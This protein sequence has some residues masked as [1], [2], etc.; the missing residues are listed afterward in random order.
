MLEVGGCFGYGSFVGFV[1]L[2][3]VVFGQVGVLGQGDHHLGKENLGHLVV[4]LGG[5][6]S[7]PVYALY[8]HL[9]GVLAACDRLLFV[10]V[11][12]T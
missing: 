4:L 8:L 11:I 5:D 1:G 3:L 2:F 9:L 10:K 6:G 12:R 7:V